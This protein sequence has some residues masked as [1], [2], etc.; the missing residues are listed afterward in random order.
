VFQLS[1]VPLMLVCT[2]Y[3]TFPLVLVI[4]IIVGPV[5]LIS[6]DG[7]EVDNAS[8]GIP[9][10]PHEVQPMAPVPGDDLSHRLWSVPTT[11]SR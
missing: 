10:R 5:S 7:E 4:L 3:H 9:M 8:G 1:N 2:L 6:A 11:T